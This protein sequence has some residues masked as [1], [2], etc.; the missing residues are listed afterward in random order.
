MATRRRGAAN[1]DDLKAKLGYSEPVATP[2]ADEASGDAPAGT[3]ASD[4]GATFPDAAPAPS[5]DFGA[6]PDHAAGYIDEPQTFVPPVAAAH[7]ASVPDE[8]YSNAVSNLESETFEYDANAVDP[9]IKAP[10][11][12]SLMATVIAV[13]AAALVGLAIGGIGVAN[14]TVRQFQNL[15]IA[16]AG[17]VRDVVQPISQE[18]SALNADLAGI[19]AE[20]TYSPTFE[21]RLR[22]S[23]GESR[24]VLDPALV[25][26]AK[27]LIVRNEQIGRQLVEYAVATSY[28]GS[29]VDRHLRST[30][31]DADEIASLQAGTQDELNYG[32]AFELNTVLG[33]YNDFLTDR[34]AN[35]FSPVSAERVTFSELEM[36]TEGEGDQANDFYSVTTATGEEIQVLVHDLIVLP[37]E[38]LLP[39]VSNE[40]AL[41]RYKSRA[42]QIKELIEQASSMQTALLSELEE[43]ANQSPLFTF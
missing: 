34:E 12:K 6:A 13:A 29:T 31:R 22:A 27:T 20:Q 16:D 10:A 14:N 21:E 33:R 26:N 1:L 39:P 5:Q 7:A 2:N 30:I 3:P 15:S 19:P 11:S 41:D 8:D 35:P 9:T 18:L 43:I 36:V 23:Y 37:R 40:N 4:A 25:S 42:A 17:R 24:P 28:L 38:H 32:I